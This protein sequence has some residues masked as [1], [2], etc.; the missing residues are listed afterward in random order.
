MKCPK[1]DGFMVYEEVNDGTRKKD[2]YK[3]VNCGTYVVDYRD[4][5][6]CFVCGFTKCECKGKNW[7]NHIPKGKGK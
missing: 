6:K 5:W 1:C 7:K 4:N 3:C 2:S